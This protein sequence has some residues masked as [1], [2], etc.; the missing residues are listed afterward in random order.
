MTSFTCGHCGA[1]LD[2]PDE[3]NALD[4]RCGFC[5]KS[6]PLP[7]EVLDVRFR[8][9]GDTTVAPPPRNGAPFLALGAVVAGIGAT[10]VALMALGTTG[11][12]VSTAPPVLSAMPVEAPPVVPAPSLPPTTVKRPNAGAA[13]VNV[14]METLHAAGCKDV[15]LPPSETEGDQT[16]DTKFIMNGRCVTVLAMSGDPRN[17]LKLSMKTPLGAPITTPE[18]SDKVEFSYCPKMAGAHPTTIV[19]STDGPYT[20]SAIECPKNAV[21]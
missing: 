19:P 21:R 4:V 2:I 15:I 1:A 11:R 16:L 3:E 14:R 18:A 8:R 13:E 10:V 5:G 6:T 12:D 17:R 20:V 9:R 7:R